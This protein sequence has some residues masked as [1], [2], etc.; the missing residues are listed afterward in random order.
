MA[1]LIENHGIVGNDQVF[2][3]G[4]ELLLV[5]ERFGFR[6]GFERSELVKGEDR[7]VNFIGSKPFADE[8]DR[9][10]HRNDDQDLDRFWKS[11]RAK[12]YLA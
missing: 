5:I 3:L 7:F 6:R 1:S 2:Q 12:L 8:F 11:A 4:D 10:P 9:R